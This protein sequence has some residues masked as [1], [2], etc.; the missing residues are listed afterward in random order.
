MGDR[1]L[2]TGG[3][4]VC[5]ASNLDVLG[6]LEILDGRIVGLHPGEATPGPGAVRLDATGC[7]VAPGFVDLHV[8]VGE[9]GYEHREDLQSAGAAAARGGITTLCAGPGGRP[10]NDHRG[11]TEY[12]VRRGREVAGVHVR[13]VAALTRGRAG[14]R[15]TDMFDLAEGGAVA[16]GDGDRGVED[17]GLLRR[18]LEYAGGVGR[19]V[20][21]WPELPALARHGVMHEGP[22]ATRLGLKG[23]PAAAEDAAAWQAVVLAEQT[24]AR[25]HLGP[26]STAGSLRALRYA[27]EAG[28]AVTAAVGAAHL[29]LTDEAVAERYATSLRVRPPLRPRADVEALR[30][31]LAEGLIDAVTS[32]HRPQSAVEKEVE[33]DAC[34]PG[35]AGLETLLGLTLRLVDE[36]ALSLSRAVEALTAGARILG[37]DAGRLAVD[38]PAD[39]VVFD[40]AARV[41]VEADAWAS[42]SSNTPFLGQALP[43]HVRWTLVAGRVAHAAERGEGWP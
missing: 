43:G 31:G 30:A 35:M 7:V 27:R 32:L 9:P 18:A 25:V 22:V 26:V 23:V 2:I 12:L 36:G 33:F 4:L 40:P 15:L 39:V 20:F 14:E 19:P 16:F 8:E 10:P 28:L 17:A 29:H 24:G 38:A 13:P 3:R 37:L 5:P 42:R 6:T 11:A 41:R 21:V 1:I 34:A